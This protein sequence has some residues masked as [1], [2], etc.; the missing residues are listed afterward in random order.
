M[1]KN[2]AEQIEPEDFCGKDL[3]LVAE[4]CSVSV[5]ASLMNNMPGLT[6]FIPVT[7]IRK[8]RDKYIIK[9][10]DGSLESIKRIS[11]NAKITERHV[12]RIIEKLQK[13]GKIAKDI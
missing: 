13:E 3:Q 8:T 2:W 10:Y 12:Y 11:I 9:T 1:D 4:L 5:A 7:A 6:I